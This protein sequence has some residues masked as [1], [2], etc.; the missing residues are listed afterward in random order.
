MGVISTPFERVA[1]GVISVC[2]YME[3]NFFF[4]L[5]HQA[6]LALVKLADALQRDA[7]LRRNDSAWLAPVDFI[8]A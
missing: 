3:F 7:T 4:G 8:G 2:L 1:V 6:K 5:P